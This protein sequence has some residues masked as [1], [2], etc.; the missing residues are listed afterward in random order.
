[1]AL[2]TDDAVGNLPQDATGRSMPTTR[3]CVNFGLR[4]RP[5]GT[6]TI[7]ITA[8]SGAATWV[9]KEGTTAL[10]AAVKYAVSLANVALL[11]AQAINTNAAAHNWVATVSTDTITLRQRRGG[12]SGTIALT[13]TGDAAGAPANSGDP[14][15]DTDT[16]TEYVSGGGAFDGNLYYELGWSGALVV[17]GVAPGAA[18]GTT[19]YGGGLTNAVMDEISLY[20]N[21]Q[22]FA[23]WEGGLRAL[24][25]ASALVSGIP[26][27]TVTWS[28]FIPWLNCVQPLVIK[29]AADNTALHY[30]A[31]YF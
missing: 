30:K 19:T 22:A 25:D 26:I 24:A 21:G 29:V 23:Y 3:G 9:Y 17:G 18:L 13:A 8:G 20:S 11:I 14:T 5:L 4:T 27:A 31:K 1:M 6:I 7:Q 2:G 10:H 15:G 28:D 12:A 16:W